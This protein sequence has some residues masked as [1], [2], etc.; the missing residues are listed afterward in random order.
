MQTV[1]DTLVAAKK[2]YERVYFRPNSGNA[3]DAL[4]NVGF[5][6]IAQKICLEYEEIS[7]DFP[8]EE[9]SER[10]LVVLSG[11]GN[12]VS[13]WSAGSALVQ[14]LTQYKF[15]LLL[16]PQ[17]IEGREDILGLLRERDVL[18]L[19]E[20]YSFEYACALGLKCRLALDSD[21]AFFVDRTLFGTACRA[22]PALSIRNVR[23]MAYVFWHRLRSKATGRLVALRTDRESVTLGRKRKFNDISLVAKFGTRDRELNMLSAYWL[24]KVLSWYDVVE[25]DRLHVFVGC[26]LVGTKVILHE[27]AY[28]KIKGVYEYSV[29]AHPTYAPLVQLANNVR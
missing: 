29:R 13:Y 10:D 16:M 18:F 26:V 4:I 27:N 23:K 17:S 15:P 9:L 8:Y 14:R 25:T 5:Y 28:Y 11:G 19:R 20:K 24:L 22:L 1:F 21:L 7:D 6:S 2:R 3:G 12:I